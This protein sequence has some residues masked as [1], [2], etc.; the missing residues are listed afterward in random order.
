MKKFSILLIGLMLLV[1]AGPT[2]AAKP[3][4]ATILHCG[5]VW[6]GDITATMEYHELNI[7][8]K[9]RGHDAHIAGSIDSCKNGEVWNDITEVFDDTFSDFVRNGDDCQVDGPPLGDPIFACEGD[10]APVAGDSC[11]VELLN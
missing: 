5:C 8:A 10:P 7:S 1:L 9:S 11:G 6:D 3:D 2:L 4:K